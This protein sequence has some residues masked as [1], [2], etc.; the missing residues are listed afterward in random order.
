MKVC[1]TPGIAFASLCGKAAHHS[2]SA[3]SIPGLALLNLANNRLKNLKVRTLLSATLTR[4]ALFQAAPT[5]P[6]AIILSQPISLM[7]D[8]DNLAT[9]PKLQNL[10]LLENEVT[11]Q[12]NYR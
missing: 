5:E 12:P 10:S 1:H 8:L 9:L 2:V 7:Q 4:Q 11:K 3:A 6:S